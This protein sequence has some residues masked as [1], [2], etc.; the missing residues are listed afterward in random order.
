[1]KWLLYAVTFVNLLLASCA[2]VAATMAWRSLRD[3]RRRLAARSTR[4]MQQLD[5]EVAALTSSYASLSTTLKRHVAKIGM[6]DVRGRRKAASELDHTDMSLPAETRRA[7][8]N[9]KLRSGE[10]RVYG[11]DGQERGDA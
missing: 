11:D 9:Q 3:L 7:I 5:A 4:S 8:L 6:Q 2:G 1:M 10:L